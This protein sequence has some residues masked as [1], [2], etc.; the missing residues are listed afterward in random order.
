[1]NDKM[2][3]RDEYKKLCSDME[4]EV[5]LGKDIPTYSETASRW[6]DVVLSRLDFTVEPEP[7]LPGVTPGEWDYQQAKKNTW[8]VFVP[9]KGSI[10]SDG[11]TGDIHIGWVYGEHNARVM[12]GSKKLVELVVALFLRDKT[13]ITSNSYCPEA[14]EIFD[15]LEKMGADLKGIKDA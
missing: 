5:K 1:M 9:E 7:I 6:V 10:E 8:E 11:T 4:S 13:I 3:T 14:Q 2:I 15:Q 12:T